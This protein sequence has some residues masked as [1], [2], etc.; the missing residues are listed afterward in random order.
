M[1]L[2]VGD[3]VILG[4]TQEITK[5]IKELDDAVFGVVSENPAYLMN[6]I[7]FHKIIPSVFAPFCRFST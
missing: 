6:N 7:K 1:Q 3:V 4:G 2:E 5:C